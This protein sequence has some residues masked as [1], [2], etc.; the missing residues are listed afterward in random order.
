MIL[1]Q[2]LDNHL[3]DFKLINYFKNNFIKKN[4]N[5]YECRNEK[6]QYYSYG[7]ATTNESFTNTNKC[8]SNSNIFLFFL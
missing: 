8:K 3:E 7:R 2:F 6:K 4:L 1:N 5:I